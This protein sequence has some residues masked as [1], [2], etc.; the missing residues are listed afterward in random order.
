MCRA[1]RSFSLLSLRASRRPTVAIQA[2]STSKVGRAAEYSNKG[3]SPH[4]LRRA[5]RLA[6]RTRQTQPCS[7]T[8]SGRGMS[9]QRKKAPPRL[10]KSRRR[11]CGRSLSFSVPDGIGYVLVAHGHRRRRPAHHAYDCAFRHLQGQEHSCSCVPG[12][13]EACFSHAGPLQQRLPG[14]IVGIRLDRAAEPVC[15]DSA[16]LHPEL[17]SPSPLLILFAAVIF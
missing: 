15:E 8:A 5:P 10:H 12:V 7:L 2:D 13:V 14:V 1:K 9:S 6:Q 11:F 3:V 17:T 16:R 4:P